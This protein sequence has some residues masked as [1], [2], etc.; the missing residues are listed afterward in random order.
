MENIIL[1]P[2]AK[3]RSIECNSV[4]FFLSINYPV[5]QA[6]DFPMAKYF[7]FNESNF[8]KYQL[9][10]CYVKIKCIGLQTAEYNIC[11]V[12]NYLHGLAT[13]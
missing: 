9:S 13:V 3:K 8:S 10:V 1:S 11:A 2:S 7:A 12:W 5:S 6:C 4:T